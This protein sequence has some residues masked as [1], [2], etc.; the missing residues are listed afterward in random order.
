VKRKILLI[1]DDPITQ[2]LLR[3]TFPSDGFQVFT[4]SSR[5]NAVFQLYLLQPDLIILDTPQPGMDRGKVVERIRERSS[6]P[7]VVLSALAEHGI[8]L[9]SLNRGADDF[10]AKPFSTRELQA[11]VRALLRRSQFCFA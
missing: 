11:R 6:V 9:E 1:G 4:T 7:I 10:I 2:D 5:M 3:S 8:K